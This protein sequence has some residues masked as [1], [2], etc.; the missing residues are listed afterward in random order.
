MTKPVSIR[1]NLDPPY[2]GVPVR[3]TGDPSPEL[4]SVRAV[5]CFGL[6]QYV[7]YDVDDPNGRGWFYADITDAGIADRLIELFDQALNV[8][9]IL[10]AD[11][12]PKPITG[13]FY[14]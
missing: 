14:L 2:K 11:D 12:T 13:G 3:M 4:I 9:G 8:E 7:V 6:D 5:E 1:V 10:D